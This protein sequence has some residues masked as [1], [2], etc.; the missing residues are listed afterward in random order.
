LRLPSKT[1]KKERDRDE[2]GDMGWDGLGRLIGG[3]V[4]VVMRKRAEEGYG[5]DDVSHYHGEYSF[6]Y[7]T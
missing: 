3:D 1:Q 4:G 5:V 2:D 7:I 6:A